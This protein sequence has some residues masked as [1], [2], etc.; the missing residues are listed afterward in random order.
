MKI[1]VHVDLDELA[2]DIGFNT[3]HYLF[4]VSPD[5]EIFDVQSTPRDGDVFLPLPEIKWEEKTISGLDSDFRLAK[6]FTDSLND[7]ATWQGQTIMG[8]A[9]TDVFYFEVQ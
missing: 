8:Q 7:P 1:T 9:V 5:G 6:E 4:V 3:G 2:H